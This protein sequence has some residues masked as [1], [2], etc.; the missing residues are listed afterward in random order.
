MQRI[1][2]DYYLQDISYLVYYE[3]GTKGVDCWF[4]TETIRQHRVLSFE[5]FETIKPE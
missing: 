3:I 1:I 5:D 4:D 2:K